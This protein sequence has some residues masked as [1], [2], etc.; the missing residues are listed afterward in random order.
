MP[1][2]AVY[3]LGDP[4]PKTGYRPLIEVVRQP[5][6]TSRRCRRTGQVTY[7]WRMPNSARRRGFPLH[8][9]P[10]G[11]NFV[12]AVQRAIKLNRIYEDFKKANQIKAN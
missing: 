11:G 12:E 2:C 3:I 10:L 6:M 7:Y 5:N 8:A 9:E 4:W 1:N